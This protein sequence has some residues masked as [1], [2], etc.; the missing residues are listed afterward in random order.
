MKRKEKGLPSGEKWCEVH[1]ESAHW[2]SE[3]SRHPWNRKKL[4]SHKQKQTAALVEAAVAKQISLLV[5][6]TN[7]D[8][9]ISPPRTA[10]LTMPSQAAQRPPDGNHQQSL[11]QIATAERIFALISQLDNTGKIKLKGLLKN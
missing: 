3:C 4:K 7:P 10:S 5:S 6:T 11:Q 1:E 8:S 2:D 9:K